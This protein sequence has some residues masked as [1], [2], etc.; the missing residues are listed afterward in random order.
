[1]SLC[2]IYVTLAVQQRENTHVFYVMHK[3]AIHDFLISRTILNRENEI[4]TCESQIMSF[5]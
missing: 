4:L 3:I 5:S 1:M 2:C